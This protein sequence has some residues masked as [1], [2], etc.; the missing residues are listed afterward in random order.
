V[1]E[2]SLNRPVELQI[3]HALPLGAQ[4]DVEDAAHLYVLSG[5]AFGRRTSKRASRSSG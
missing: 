1:A 3:A 5:K 2:R 4:Q